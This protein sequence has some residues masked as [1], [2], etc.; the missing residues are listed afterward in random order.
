MEAE[1]ISQSP[2]KKNIA[3]WRNSLVVYVHSLSEYKR[4]LAK[5]SGLLIFSDTAADDHEVAFDAVEHGDAGQVAPAFEVEFL[6]E[7]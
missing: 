6:E 4:Q 3:H 5:M 2:T 7:A 1:A